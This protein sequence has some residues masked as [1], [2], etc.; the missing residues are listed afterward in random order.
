MGLEEVTL[1]GVSCEG[2]HSSTS[3]PWDM[4]LDMS[5]T[6]VVYILPEMAALPFLGA[7]TCSD[8]RRDWKEELREEEGEERCL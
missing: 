8:W 1:D 3:L 7:G 2:L 6:C 5:M 4:L